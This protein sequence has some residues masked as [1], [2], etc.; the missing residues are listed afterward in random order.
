[1][2]AGI[3][4]I[5]APQGGFFCKPRCGEEYRRREQKKAGIPNRDI[6]ASLKKREKVE[7]KNEIKLSGG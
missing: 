1:M 4:F 5:T 2:P 3:R 7:K 6:P